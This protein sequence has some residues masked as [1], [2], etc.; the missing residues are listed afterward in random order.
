MPVLRPPELLQRHSW[1][2]GVVPLAHRLDCVLALNG[3]G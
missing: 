3:G 1:R 2:S